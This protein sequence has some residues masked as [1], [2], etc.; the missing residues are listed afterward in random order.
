MENKKPEEI[1]ELFDQAQ[2]MV[3]DEF[4]DRVKYFA[5]SW[6]PA[7]KIVE[8]AIKKRF[9]VHESG[10]IIELEKYCPWQEHLLEL[11]AEFKDVNIKFIV[12]QGNNGEGYRVQGVP[13]HKGSFVCRK[14][15]AKN[16]RGLTNVALI[17][18]SGILGSIF[19]HATGYI[20]GNRMRNKAIEM[21]VK[22][23]ED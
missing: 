10:E 1:D 14:L 15:L 23:L 5:L 8:E 21:A 16:W 7:K 4:L 2:K 12:H 9:D 19:V 6:L 17:N 18:E 3:G 11:E 22:S 13:I 20:G